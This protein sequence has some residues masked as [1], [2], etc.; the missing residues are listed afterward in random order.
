MVC[1]R[2]FATAYAHIVGTRYATPLDYYALML[3][4]Y[5]AMLSMLSFT[6]RHKD[7]S[8]RFRYDA[9]CHYDTAAFRLLLMPRCVTRYALPPR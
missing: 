5:A 7:A 8:R 1:C 2:C 4:P 6:L 3:C 9:P